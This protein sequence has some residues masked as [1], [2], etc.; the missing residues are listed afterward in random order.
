[1]DRV[2][3]D[4][5][6]EA[7]FMGVLR[8]DECTL[9]Q[10]EL[11]DHSP[12]RDV[13]DAEWLHAKEIDVATDWREVPSAALDQ[14]GAAMS[15]AT[16]NS[17]RFYLPAYMRRALG[18]LDATILETWIPGSVLSHLTFSQKYAGQVP[19]LLERFETLND[20]QGKAVCAFLEYVREY[21]C[22][23]APY[24]QDADL[25]LRQYWGLHTANRPRGQIVLP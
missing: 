16:P 14:C 19:Y 20:A 10:A 12:E 25:A 15:H 11:I 6:I 21:P 22:V 24:R 4:G 3:L 13:S 7:A 2:R 18:L 23:V 1:M 5:I 9:H 17:W 8:D